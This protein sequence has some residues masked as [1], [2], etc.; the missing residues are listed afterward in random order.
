MIC[1]QCERDFQ[2]EDMVDIIVCRFFHVP[3]PEKMCKSCAKRITDRGDAWSEKDVE[4]Y[5]A[6]VQK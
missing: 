5:Y 4:D 6:R 2:C 1:L 3:G